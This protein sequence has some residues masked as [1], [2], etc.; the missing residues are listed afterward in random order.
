MRYYIYS[1]GNLL[2]Y[3]AGSTDGLSAQ[4]QVGGKAYNKENS[5][6]QNG[7]SIMARLWYKK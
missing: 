5:I 2:F 1:L 6:M 7:D 4:Y 3:A